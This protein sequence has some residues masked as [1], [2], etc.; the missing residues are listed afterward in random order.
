[1]SLTN[2]CCDD[3]ITMPHPFEGS[4]G[5]GGSKSMDL[6]DARNPI[7]DEVADTDE[8]SKIFEDFKLVPFA[9]RDKRSGH[10]LLTWYLMLSQLSP[11]NAACIEKI[12]NYVVGSRAKFI[13]AEDPEYDPGTEKQPMTAQESERFEQ[14]LKD[15]VV[16]EG[17]VIEF[18]KR[19]L[20]SAK[21]TGNAFVEC[22][23][24]TVNGQTKAHFRYL[25]STS[26]LY[27][28]TKPGEI[29]TVAISPVWDS[30]Y[31]KKYPLQLVPVAPY[32]SEEKNVFRTV[33]HLKV[34][35]NTWYG[36][37]DSEGS[38]IYKYREVQDSIYVTKQSAGNFV[39][40]VI[41][42]VEDGDAGSDPAIDNEDAKKAGFKSFIDR[43]VQ[44]F[45]NKGKDPKSIVVTARAM[46][47]KAM[48]LFQIKPNTN[49]K[50]YETTGK[51][52]EQKIIMS[53]G[54][55]QR[56][57]GLDVSNGFATD[58][59]V[60]DYVMN[61]EP[62]INET[63]VELMAFTNKMLSFVWEFAGMPEMN[64]FSLTFSSPIQSQIEQYKTQSD[65][66]NTN[67]TV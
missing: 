27:K 44:N 35:D 18:H 8:I 26:V 6:F 61:V 58:A 39:G 9:T 60:A 31:L 2:G 43:M 23:I 56:F 40:Q 25:K 22:S 67:N 42:E 50:W 65:G 48:T 51:I 47:A 4:R 38:D 53:H 11:T 34:G 1:M 20:G 15:V 24:T 45:T 36:R 41:I 55:T 57:M 28:V 59:F 14:A 33:F 66:G 19:V 3:P 46:G 64:Q 10:A 32:F 16:F 21:K 13:R 29:K 54:L 62:T 5:M 37:P 7:P 63:R 49:E 17:G 12:K 30:V 52:S